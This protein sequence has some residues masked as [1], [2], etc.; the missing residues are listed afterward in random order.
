[1]ALN[2]NGPTRASTYDEPTFNSSLPYA[3]AEKKALAVARVP[4]P[5]FDRSTE[6]ADIITEAVQS[7]ILGA[8]TPQAAMDRLAPRLEALI[9]A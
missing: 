6:A 9:R 4:L 1:M 7:A 2:G 8:A 3:E 5:A